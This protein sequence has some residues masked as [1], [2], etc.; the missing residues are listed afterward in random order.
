MGDGDNFEKV[1]MEETTGDKFA[2]FG[3]TAIGLEVEAFP[4]F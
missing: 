1:L 3:K 2:L 4:C